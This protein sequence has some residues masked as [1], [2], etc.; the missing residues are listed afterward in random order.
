MAGLKIGIYKSL[1]DISKNWKFNKKFYPK[2]NQNL[3]KELINGWLKTV[4]K[5]INQNQ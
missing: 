1:D 5:T 3:R 2:I 4:N